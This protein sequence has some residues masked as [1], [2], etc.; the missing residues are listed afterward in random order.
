LKNCQTWI[1][2]GIQKFG[3]RAE[4]ESDKVTPARSNKYCC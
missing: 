4:S 1:Q 2:T 3:T